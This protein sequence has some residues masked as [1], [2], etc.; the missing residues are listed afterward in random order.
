MFRFTVLGLGVQV[1]SGPQGVIGIHVGSC[2]LGIW[3][4][5]LGFVS[6]PLVGFSS[7]SYRVL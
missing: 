5:C 6:R 4:V 1:F 2:L 7:G 3:A